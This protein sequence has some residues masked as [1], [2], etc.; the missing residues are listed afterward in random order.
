MS[1]LKAVNKTSGN[2][3]LK[4]VHKTSGNLDSHEDIALLCSR[5]V[6]LYSECTIENEDGVHLTLFCTFLACDCMM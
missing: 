4:A 1:D 5:A 2:L 3:D 6:V